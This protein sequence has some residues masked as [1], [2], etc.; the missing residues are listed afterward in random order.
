MEHDSHAVEPRCAY[1]NSWEELELGNPD[2]IKTD[3]SEISIRTTIR[4]AICKHYTR[5]VTAVKR[6][7]S[8]WLEFRA[9]IFFFL[10][11]IGILVFSATALAATARSFQVYQHHK[12]DPP[13]PP[14]ADK[15]ADELYSFEPKKHW[16]P[17]QRSWPERVD[18]EEIKGVLALSVAS[19]IHACIGIILLAREMRPG[20]I[21]FIVLSLVVACYSVRIPVLWGWSVS[22]KTRSRADPN[23]DSTVRD[24]TCAMQVKVG[25]DHIP[26]N[27]ICYE[28]VC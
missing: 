2:E 21:Q 26:Y 7:H 3:P 9:H 4:H 10:V 16:P 23:V 14:D 22:E 12:H 13:P 28:Q 8:E 19:V 5:L 11:N 24:W 17:D 20:M 18:T 15:L 25:G 6:Y 1:G 27:A